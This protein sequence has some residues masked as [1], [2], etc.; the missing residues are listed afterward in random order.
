MVYAALEDRNI[1]QD[2]EK[3]MQGRGTAVQLGRQ[4]YETH[5]D[6]FDHS[7]ADNASELCGAD[8]PGRIVR[9]M[10]VGRRMEDTV[11]SCQ[12]DEKGTRKPRF[13]SLQKN[14][15]RM[16]RQNEVRMHVANMSAQKERFCVQKWLTM[17]A[18]AFTRRQNRSIK[19]KQRQTKKPLSN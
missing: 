1:S 12:K 5:S 15:M 10:P 11:S 14:E 7:V 19:G 3:R 9:D 13:G 2:T 18:K 6:I 16:Q 8:T 17:L 4:A